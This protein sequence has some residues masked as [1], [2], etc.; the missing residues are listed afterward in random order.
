ME[1]CFDELVDDFVIRG[2]VAIMRRDLLSCQGVHLLVEYGQ[3]SGL[4]RSVSVLDVVEHS[5]GHTV[6][7]GWGTRGGWGTT[8]G[9]GNTIK[10][11]GV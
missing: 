6:G 4:S 11:G 1:E 3:G 10:G 2:V 9:A 7:G 8:G 5:Q